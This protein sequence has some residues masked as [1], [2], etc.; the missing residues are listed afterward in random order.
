MNPSRSRNVSPFRKCILSMGFLSLIDLYNRESTPGL[1]PITTPVA[2]PVVIHHTD[3]AATGANFQGCVV[4][5]VSLLVIYTFQRLKLAKIKSVAQLLLVQLLTNC[6]LS[7]ITYILHIFCTWQVWSQEVTHASIFSSENQLFF[8]DM[9]S[10]SED[11]LVDIVRLLDSTSAR[12]GMEISA[13]KTQKQWPQ[14]ETQEPQIIYQW[15]S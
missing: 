10:G 2:C 12:Y 6:T 14:W 5:C 11:A 1:S 15:K 8:I 9:M 3:V 4:S 7:P 13:D